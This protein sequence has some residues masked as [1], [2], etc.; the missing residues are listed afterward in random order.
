L[1]RGGASITLI[2]P[3]R[4][5]AA[6]LGP[7][8]ADV[9]RLLS[10]EAP[11]LGWLFGGAPPTSLPFDQRFD[12]AVAYTR[13]ATMVERLGALATVVRHWDPEPPPNVGHA[14]HW[15]SQ[16]VVPPGLDAEMAPPVQAPTEEEADLARALASRLPRRFLAIH[17]GS[18]SPAKNWPARCYA[19]LARR[20]SPERPWLLIE[21]PADSATAAPLYDAPGAVRLQEPPTRVLGALLSAAGAYVGN[22]S[23]V[24][25]LA[26]AWGAPTVALFGPTNPA[27]WAPEGP[28]VEVLRGAASEVAAIPCDVVAAAV[29]RVRS[30]ALARPSG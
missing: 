18:G 13:N 8:P 10:W 6:L 24:S 12:L 11:D 3:R 7:G 29:A 19:E 9:D 15:L 17:P 21:G 2:A 23:G 5:G 20:V 28:I 25:H 30:A 16:A 26:A 4:P 27:V 1:K 22:D 14:S